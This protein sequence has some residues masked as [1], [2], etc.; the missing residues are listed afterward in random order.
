M[1]RKSQI[2]IIRKQRPDPVYS[3][4]LTENENDQLAE[5]LKK[6]DCYVRWL[7]QFNDLIL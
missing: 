6:D 2:Q 5:K 1:I 7:I 3:L 4:C